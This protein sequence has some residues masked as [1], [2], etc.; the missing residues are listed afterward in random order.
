[1]AFQDPGA[2]HPRRTDA[3]DNAALALEAA[4][5]AF[6]GRPLSLALMERALDLAMS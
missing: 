3:A 1:M 5:L 2:L 4:V 6:R